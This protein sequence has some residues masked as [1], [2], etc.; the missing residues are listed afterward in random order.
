MKALLSR[1]ITRRSLQDVKVLEVRETIQ[2]QRQHDLAQESIGPG[3]KDLVL[4]ERLRDVGQ[5]QL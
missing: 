3:Q 2:D 4:L 5:E 1:E